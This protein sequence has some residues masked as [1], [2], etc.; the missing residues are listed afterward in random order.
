[1]PT[2][3]IELIGSVSYYR[4]PFLTI[5]GCADRGTHMTPDTVGYSNI[6]SEKPTVQ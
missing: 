3:E 4:Y 2:F 6:V 5:N 1:M